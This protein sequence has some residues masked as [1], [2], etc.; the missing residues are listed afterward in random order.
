MAPGPPSTGSAANAATL[1]SAFGEDVTLQ[2]GSVIQGVFRFGDEPFWDPVRLE[3]RQRESFA[4]YVP[5]DQRGT[6]EAGTRDTD[7]TCTLR[8]VTY[9]VRSL[10]HD[11]DGWSRAVLTKTPGA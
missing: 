5:T 10:S 11:S 8:G 7:R 6:L 3:G 4:L 1:L 9:F 2:D